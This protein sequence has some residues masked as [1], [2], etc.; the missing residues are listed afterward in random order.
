[1]KTDSYKG[2]RRSQVNREENYI[3]QAKLRKRESSRFLRT[4]LVLTILIIGIAISFFLLADNQEFLEE[5][6][7]KDNVI[8]Q[9]FIKLSQDNDTKHKADFSLPFGNKRR[10][11][12]L[13]GVD[14]NG[15]GTDP[16]EGTRTDTIILLNVDPRTKSLNALSIPRD[17]KVYLPD[18]H[19]V[20]KINAAHAIGGIGM[21]IRTI[22]ETLGVKIDRYIMVHDEAVK[23]IV[24]ALGGVDIYV[25]KNMH[26]NDYSGKLFINLKKGPNHLNGKEVIGYLRFRHDPM[27]D[28]GRTQRQQWFLR[29]MMEALKKPETITKLPEIINVASKYIKTNM[30]F[31]ELSQYAG[32]AKHLD[33][34]KIEI[35]MLPGAPNKKGYIS[36]WILD[37]EKTQEV[38]NRLIYREKIN[39]ES[40]TDVKAGIMYSDGNAEEAKLVKEQ[41]INLGINVACTG[42][43]SKTHTQ[44]VAHSKNITNDYYNW[45]KKKMPS[46]IG[47]QFVFEPNNYYCDGTDFT[48]VIA[49][50]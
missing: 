47:Y 19:G 41:L 6:L 2:P 5:N 48:V 20:Q 16:W 23:E 21:T 43:V 7:G 1:M 37:P 15:E 31:Y 26:Y 45:L 34:D 22:E 4:V 33:M 38:V 28:I 10:N 27:G 17:S 42:T 18:D 40:M 30:S 9:L 49:G 29:G 8:T 24:D 35:A 36:Y 44:F 11:I 39:P 46:I 14:S 32:F 13:L 50:K 12:L 3:R 25:E